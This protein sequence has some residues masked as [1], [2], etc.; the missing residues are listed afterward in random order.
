MI[1]SQ[2]GAFS[3]KGLCD[4]GLRPVDD[5]LLGKTNVFPDWLASGSWSLQVKS[6]EKRVLLQKTPP[7]F[8]HW[9]IAMVICS[10]D[11]RSWAVS[12]SPSGSET[13]KCDK[14]ETDH[15]PLTYN[16][17]L[18]VESNSS[19]FYTNRKQPKQSKGD[20]WPVSSCNY[21][22]P[23]AKWLGDEYFFIQ[24]ATD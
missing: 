8:D 4:W 22:Q 3:V 17:C 21:Q 9:Q 13:G 2:R 23:L 5:W 10:L 20:F 7:C 18:T 14:L 16:F 19:I 1:T 15:S 6:V 11:G 12:C 24:V